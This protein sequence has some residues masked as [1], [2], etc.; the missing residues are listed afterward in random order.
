MAQLSSY[1]PIDIYGSC[2]DYSCDRSGEGCFPRFAYQYK[3]YLSFENS[4]CRDYI[5]EKFSN[6][7][8]YNLVPIVYGAGD[9]SA[10]APPNSFI[11]AHDFANPRALAEYLLH[12][13]R[14]PKLYLQYFQWKAK[15]KV[16]PGNGLCSLC[17]K[18]KEQKRKGEVKVSEN[19]S[20]WWNFRYEGKDRNKVSVCQDP[21]VSLTDSW[22]L[23]GMVDVFK[24]MR[25]WFYKQVLGY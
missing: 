1:I 17:R 23:I 20:D 3:F 21:A 2:G 11:N 19:L 13:D 25:R 15:Y 24:Y 10:V 8:K 5:T 14:N 9:Y 12:L 22:N 18:T 7:L 4:L 16:V 6:A